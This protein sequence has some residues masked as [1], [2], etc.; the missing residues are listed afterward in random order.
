MPDA[1]SGT[2]ADS[3]RTRGRAMS[4]AREG[5]PGNQCHQFPGDPL[6][7]HYRGQAERRAEEVVFRSRMK[8]VARLWTG[9]TLWFGGTGGV[10]TWRGAPDEEETVRDTKLKRTR[11][12]LSPRRLSCR[13][14]REGLGTTPDWPDAVKLEKRESTERKEGDETGEKEVIRVKQKSDVTRPR[15]ARGVDGARPGYLGGDAQQR[16]IGKP[17]VGDRH[18]SSGNQKL[19]VGIPVCQMG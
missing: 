5:S 4:E 15:S 11:F 8:S 9:C 6:S 19:Q 2:T 10:G 3:G 12:L 16:G 1:D 7:P 13:A 17:R 14:W 18:D